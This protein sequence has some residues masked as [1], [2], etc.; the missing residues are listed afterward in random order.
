MNDLAEV[1]ISQQLACDRLS[2]EKGLQYAIGLAQALRRV[3]QQGTIYT[4]LHPDQILVN[5]QGL[6]LRGSGVG[7]LTPYASPEQLLG[8]NPDA[9][10]DI[11]AYGAVLYELLSGR[12]AFPADDPDELRRQIL[13]DN[14]PQPE[15]ITDAV[16]AVLTRCLEKRPEQRW[17]RMSSVLIELKLAIAH[18]RH[19]QQVS[20]WKLKMT[21]QRAQ[22][23]AI[24][25]RL[26][27]YE[28]LHQQTALDLRNS[29]QDL[30]GKAERQAADLADAH[31][32]VSAVGE[33]V[34]ALQ[35]TAQAFSR[36]IDSLQS[37]AT[38]TDEVVEHVVDALG[39]MHK[40]ILESAAEPIA[41][42]SGN[43]G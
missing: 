29:I 43:A 27:V 26:A 15:N 33:N 5:E 21:S 6:S 30:E 18:D 12:R 32:A 16:N 36:A 39:L 41:V 24:E 35:K 7:G 19:A 9:R 38:Q 28:T 23:A 42:V 8:E 3:H 22:I 20:E 14:P 13:E 31:G 17:Q 2:V 11:F 40:S 25:E 34:T 1:T 10:S 37:A 4:G